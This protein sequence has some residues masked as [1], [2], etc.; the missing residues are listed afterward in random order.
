VVSVVIA[1]NKV[2]AMFFRI[3]VILYISIILT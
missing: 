3:A 2:L 1:S